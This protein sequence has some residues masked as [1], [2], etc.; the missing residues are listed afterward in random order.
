MTEIA[1]E[2]LPVMTHVI[3]DDDGANVADLSFALGR[4]GQDVVRAFTKPRGAAAYMRRSY[5]DG[6]PSFDA[7]WLDSMVGGNIAWHQIVQEFGGVTLN[8][9]AVSGGDAELVVPSAEL[10]VVVGT[11]T[12]LARARSIASNVRGAPIEGPLCL[13]RDIHIPRMDRLRG[14]LRAIQYGRCKDSWHS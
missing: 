5:R 8:T 10:T 4:A 7:L 1:G 14:L 11:S 6:D 2:I 12:D 9:Y 13:N 3:M